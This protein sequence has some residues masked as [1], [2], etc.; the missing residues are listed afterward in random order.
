MTRTVLEEYR[1]RLIALGK[2]LSRDREHLKRGAL[3]TAGGETSGSFSDVPLHPADLGTHHFEEEVDLTLLEN[4]EQL[5]EEVNGALE[6]IEAGTFGRCVECHK[7]IPPRRLRVV[8]Y[9]RFCIG[10]ARKQPRTGT[11]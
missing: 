7:E 8:P 2:T 10:C 4:E 11:P 3:Q 9:T 1:D 5:L 6:R